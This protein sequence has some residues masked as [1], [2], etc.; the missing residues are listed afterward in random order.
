[1]SLCFKSNP[2]VKPNLQARCLP[3]FFSDRAQAGGRYR[4]F[5]GFLGFPIG[6]PRFHFIRSR[7]EHHPF[8]R[9]NRSVRLPKCAVD[10]RH[11]P[12]RQFFLPRVAGDQPCVVN[13]DCLLRHIFQFDKNR[14]SFARIIPWNDG[15]ARDLK[16]LRLGLNGL[17]CGFLFGQTF[18]G[19]ADVKRRPRHARRTN[20]QH[21]TQR[22]RKKQFFHFLFLVS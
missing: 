9:P 5:D 16:P 21:H 22:S 13:G 17:I 6:D 7:K 15:L 2:C 18:F 10:G 19:K 20:A 14:P 4:F 1:M 8:A 3:D 12:A 11:A